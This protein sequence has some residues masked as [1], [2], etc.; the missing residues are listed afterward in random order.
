[1]KLQVINDIIDSSRVRGL[2]Y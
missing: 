2:V 1:D